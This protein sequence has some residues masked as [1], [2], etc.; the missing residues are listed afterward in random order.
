MKEV[1]IGNSQGDE[2]GT[3]SR[4]GK[5]IKLL[6]HLA[7]TYPAEPPMPGRMHIGQKMSPMGE[8]HRHTATATASPQRSLPSIG[9]QEG[10][11]W[12]RL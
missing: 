9:R 6:G 10:I 8:A 12:W 4:G 5:K 3:K 11:D 1:G 7:L 2:A